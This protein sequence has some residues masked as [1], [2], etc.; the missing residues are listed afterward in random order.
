MA[1]QRENSAFPGDM[2]RLPA[3]HGTPSEKPANENGNHVAARRGAMGNGVA[4]GADAIQPRR[5]TGSWTGSMRRASDVE[6]RHE[7]H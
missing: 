6:R 2:G 3:L 1:K 7:T 4:I 5:W